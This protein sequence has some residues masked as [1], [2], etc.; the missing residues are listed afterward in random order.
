M[1]GQ[2]KSENSK[3]V[4]MIFLMFFFLLW[5]FVFIRW[6]YSNWNVANLHLHKTI[7]CLSLRVTASHC[8]DRRLKEKLFV[9]LQSCDFGDFS[10]LFSQI[11]CLVYL[12]EMFVN[13][14]L[15]WKTKEKK[16]R[17]RITRIDLIVVLNL[18]F[19]HIEWTRKLIFTK[20]FSNCRPFKV[21]RS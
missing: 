3:Q 19:I 11:K 5:P 9:H 20:C 12:L 2:Q 7:W 8:K 13:L 1:F 16:V 4:K 14:L 10:L 18:M 6:D 15:T 21:L 17:I